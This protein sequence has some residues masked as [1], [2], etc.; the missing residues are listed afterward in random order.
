MANTYDVGDAAT[1]KAKFTTAAGAAVDPTT[2][3]LK[4]L[5]PDGTQSTPTPTNPAV[6]EYEYVQSLTKAGKWLYRFEGTGAAVAAGAGHLIVR[7]N[8]FT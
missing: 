1:L 5:D 8:P 6:G 4:V 7:T 2:V 3:V